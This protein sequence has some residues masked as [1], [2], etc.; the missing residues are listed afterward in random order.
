MKMTGKTQV[1][2]L[3][4][5]MVC[6]LSG[7]GLFR[8]KIDLTDYIEYNY[9]GINGY[10]ELFYSVDTGKISSDYIEKISEKEMDSFL[11]VLS[12]MEIKASKSEKLCNNDVITFTVNYSEEDCKNAGITFVGNNM[13]ITVEGLQ[14]GELIDLF[15]DISVNVQGIA[16]FA[17]ASIENKSTNPYIQ[18]LVYTLDKTTGFNA[19]DVLNV[20]CNA[21]KDSAGEYGY[22]FLEAIKGYSTAGID[23]YIKYASEIDMNTLAEVVAEAENTV[24]SEAE[25]SQSRMLYKVTGS[26][27]Y[28]F[29]YNKEWIDSVEVTEIKLLTLADDNNYT[30][31]GMPVNKLYV[32]FKAYVTNADHGNDGY[33]CFEYDNLVKKGDSTLE[34][35]HDNPQ[36]RYLCDDDYNQLMEK[37]EKN[38]NDYYVEQT[39]QWVTT[40]ENAQ[41]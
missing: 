33:F 23:A 2:A 1:F 12:N 35:K 26:S 8:T 4:L 17:T 37:V 24:K 30:T 6:I 7:C 41:N 36:L 13:E 21:T 32:I 20:T 38:N 40:S 34:I 22:V 25:D 39:I 9:E 5:L 29:Q 18:G 15:A 16:P 14:E 19:G 3:L 11:N 27:N 10:T 28:L 31:L